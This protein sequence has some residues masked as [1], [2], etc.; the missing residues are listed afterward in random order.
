MRGRSKI[1]RLFV[2]RGGAGSPTEGAEPPDVRL[3]RD[4]IAGCA[5]AQERFLDRMVCL[6]KTA[7]LLNRR[8]A[9]ALPR[10]R[11]E[12]VAQEA[13][14]RIWSSL[15]KFEGRGNLET[16][17]YA[18]VRYSYYEA[19]RD[20]RGVGEG[21]GPSHVAAPRQPEPH[22]LAA[23]LVEIEPHGAFAALEALPP[24]WSELVRAKALDGTPFTE[25]E[26]RFGRPAATLRSHYRQALGRMQRALRL[27]GGEV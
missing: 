26:G 9:R 22:E 13:F 17:C 6:V 8:A 15:G 12:D 3:V 1:E 16:W 4:V 14:C 19:Q 21:R 2:A 23:A 11:L 5:V 10:E 27:Q 18:F 25:L 7:H 20:L 24:A